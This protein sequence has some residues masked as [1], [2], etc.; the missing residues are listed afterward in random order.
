MA[1]TIQKKQTLN[2]ELHTA[3]I[4]LF[5]SVLLV[6]AALIGVFWAL[7][8]RGFDPVMLL[9]LV[10]I[11]YFV[12]EVYKKQ[13][14]IEIIK[15]GIKGE[16][17]ALKTLA[18]ALPEGYTILNCVIVRYHEQKS[19]VDNIIVG[20]TGV[21]ACEVKTLNG[22]VKGDTRKPHWMQAK[23]RKGKLQ[24]KEFYNPVMQVI[25]HK[26]RIQAYLKQ[27]G[28]ATK[29]C[30]MVFF[31]GGRTKLQVEGPLDGIRLFT[32]ENL[33]SLVRF[34]TEGEQ[35]LDKAEIKKIIH[36]LN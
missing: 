9:F 35:V 11:S 10:P 5:S 25:T 34:V 13:Q 26:E 31:A 16:A 23:Q 20:P 4:G 14:Q 6:V 22:I 24:K 1:K 27:E 30:G 28:F 12:Y 7:W 21:Y 19:Q 33:N 29:P 36:A 18:A 32:E 3:R 17:Q 2:V 15:A 8:Y